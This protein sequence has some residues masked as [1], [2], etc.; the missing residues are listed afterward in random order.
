[1]SIVSLN[2]NCVVAVLIG[3][4]VLLGIVE[5]VDGIGGEAMGSL[6]VLQRRVEVGY[7]TGGEEMRS[8]LV[9]Q[10]LVEVVDTIT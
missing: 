1:M 4:G 7:R 8:L 6:P 3:H 10:G 5:V 2:D 9:L